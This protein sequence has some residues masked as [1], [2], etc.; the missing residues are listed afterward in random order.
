MF[1][2][3][4]NRHLKFNR[5]IIALENLKFLLVSD[6]ALVEKLRGYKG[7]VGTSGDKVML[8]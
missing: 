7:E 2:I 6:A 1:S 5:E 3:Y 8:V 4:L